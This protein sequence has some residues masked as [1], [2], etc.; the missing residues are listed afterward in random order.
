MNFIAF[1]IL[2]ILSAGSFQAPLHA[3][4]QNPHLIAM[5]AAPYLMPEDH[6]IKS[7]LDY[8][9]SQSRVTE[10][11]A[12]LEEAGFEIIVVTKVSHVIVARHPA[13]P[14]Y[15]FKVYLDSET[16]A[17]RDAPYWT[18][19]VT[20]CKGALRV[21]KAIRQKK[22]RYF[23]VPDKWL[24]LLPEYPLSKEQNPQPL[25]LVETDMEIDD[26]ETTRKKW[27]NVKSKHLDELY[28]ILKLGYGST[29]LAANVPSTKNGKFAFID[30]EYTKRRLPLEKV[31]NF[32]SPEMRIY[33]D[34]LYRK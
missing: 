25:I 20:R 5:T 26:E 24:Y 16:R 34:T 30:T 4:P 2:L 12:T 10:N 23:T 17:V 9:F 11:L 15:I 22:L 19:L 8:L 21:K 32:L 33:W 31:K 7:L 27:L 29:S 6:P 18:H 1:C 28:E 13:F 14:G 3:N